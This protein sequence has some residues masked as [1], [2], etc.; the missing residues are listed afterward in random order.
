MYVFLGIEGVLRPHNG[1]PDIFDVSARQYFGAVMIKHQQ[2]KIVLTSSWRLQHS[3]EHIKS[4]F[5]TKI[6]PLIA[7][8]TPDL[9]TTTGSYKQTEIEYY[10][11]QKNCEKQQWIAID[12]KASRFNT[13]APLF[14]TDSMQG[15]TSSDA[16]HLHAKLTKIE[17]LTGVSA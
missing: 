4:L 5:P 13:N 1:I 10:L 15:F 8:A 2:W 9:G 17:R 6:R 7:G 14:A 16:Q 3:M 12:D 11:L